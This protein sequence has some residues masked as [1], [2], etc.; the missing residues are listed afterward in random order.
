MG[1]H[2]PQQSGGTRWGA[3]APGEQGH[4]VGGG[5]WGAQAPG[6]RGH[7]VEGGGWGA[8]RPPAAPMS[9]C[10]YNL[11]GEASDTLMFLGKESGPGARGPLDSRRLAWA[12]VGLKEGLSACRRWGAVSWAVSGGER[13]LKGQQLSEGHLRRRSGHVKTLSRRAQACGGSGSLQ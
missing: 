11:S 2:R 8:W 5:G 12:T 1:G 4:Q 13:A 7:R 3:Q 9:L 10:R 6:E